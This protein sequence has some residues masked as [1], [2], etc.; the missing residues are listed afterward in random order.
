LDFHYLDHEIA[1]FTEANLSMAARDIPP[2]GYWNLLGD[3][4][5]NL[6]T[7][8]LTKNGI[9]TFGRFTLTDSTNDPLPIALVSFYGALRDRQT[10][11]NWEVANE[12]SIMKYDVER[13]ADGIS[14]SKLGTVIA[15]GAQSL[16]FKYDYVDPSPFRGST[17]Y[18]LKVYDNMEKGT[19]SRS[20]RVDL[21]EAY[22]LSVYPNPVVDNVNIEFNCTELKN[23]SFQL[24]DAQGKIISVKE[25][26]TVPGANRV[27]WNI[28]AL[29]AATYYIR[30]NGL[31]ETPIKISKF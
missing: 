21:N 23:L 12:L 19:Y 22:T 17:F 24:M 6:G 26:A 16:N 3:D 10:L 25:V 29:P 28:S 11:L 27:E 13:S 7:N 2:M 18:R 20:I 30:L 4:A 5:H 8:V 31:S 15:N 9:D 1:G 14:F